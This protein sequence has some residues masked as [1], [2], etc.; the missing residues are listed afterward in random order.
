[1]RNK[2]AKRVQ[3]QGFTLVELALFVVVVSIVSALA[4]PAFGKVSQ[5]SSKARDMENARQAAAVAQGAEAAG[6]SL[7][8]P[9]STVEEMLRRLNAGVTPTRGAFSGQTFQL[10][11]S[12]AEI[13]G[14][15]RFL[16]MQNGLLVYVGP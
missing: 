14:I 8:N 9:G 16:R 15:A 10:K 11:T 5:S 6:V 2:Y 4:V 3:R 13:P 7:L 12:E 1:M